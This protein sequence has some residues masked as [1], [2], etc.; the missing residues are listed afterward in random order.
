MFGLGAAVG[1]DPA[2]TVFRS[3]GSDFVRVDLGS[4]IVSRVADGT[5]AG[6]GGGV[7][8]L[9]KL[10]VTGGEE[11]TVPAGAGSAVGGANEICGGGAV[12]KTAPSG[13]SPWVTGTCMRSLATPGG[14]GGSV[15]VR[16]VTGGSGGRGVGAART[17]GAGCTTG[18]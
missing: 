9:G 3:F 8:T 16:L 1:T 7:V 11:T 18:A 6:A 13:K 10:G 5:G 4:V 15:D 12:L 2:G 17:I 14:G